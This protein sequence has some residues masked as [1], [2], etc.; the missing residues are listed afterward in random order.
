MY[1]MTTIV[2]DTVSNVFYSEIRSQVFSSHTQNDNSE[3][4][5]VN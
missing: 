5:Y 3:E 2:S 4:R 1:S